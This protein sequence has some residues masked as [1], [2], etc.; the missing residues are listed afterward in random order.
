MPLKF[1]FVQLFARVGPN[2]NQFCW[3]EIIILFKHVLFL[4]LSTRQFEA[5]ATMEFI[6]D[7]GPAMQNLPK[8][9]FEGISIGQKTPVNSKKTSIRR[10]GAAHLLLKSCDIS[11]WG[12]S[13]LLC[14]FSNPHSWY[15]LYLFL[16]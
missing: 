14:Q 9:S 15:V 10:I 3:L 12:D 11:L 4:I 2:K 7:C 13:S 1:N 8:R 5:K 6:F 16:V